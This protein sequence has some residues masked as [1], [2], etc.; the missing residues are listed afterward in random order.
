MRA[1]ALLLLFLAGPAAAADEITGKVTGIADGDT[2]TVLSEQRKQ[3]RVRL[4]EIDAPEKKQPF[5][6]RSRQSLADLCF[7]KSARV[8]VRDIDRYGRVVGRVA[9][10]G[11]DANAEQVRRGLAWVYRKYSNDPELLALE[12]Q[13]REGRRGLWRDP[14]PTEPWIWRKI[15]RASVIV[16]ARFFQ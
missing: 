4:A 11:V 13:A 15:K 7:G 16:L 14:A 10:E 8:A 1:C 5:G 12:A 3:I 6:E 9:C 2:L